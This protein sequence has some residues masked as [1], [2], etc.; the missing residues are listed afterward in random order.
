[1]V[2]AQTGIVNFAPER[3][4]GKKAPLLRA[5]VLIC[6]RR[7]AGEGTRAT[8]VS[9]GAKAALLPTFP[10]ARSPA[11]MGD[12]KDD[13]LQE[14]F[15]IDDGEGK[16]AESVFAEIAEVEGPPLGSFF[17]AFD[18]L[19]DSTLKLLCSDWALIQIP[20]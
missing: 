11:A 15:L 17:N 7:F 12:G 1:M 19:P 14:R 16:L 20:S 5:G 3:H 9:A 8:P 18:C 13:Y 6:Y 2:R 4:K 10:V